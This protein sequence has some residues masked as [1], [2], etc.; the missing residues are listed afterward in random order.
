MTAP[1][2]TP[3]TRGRKPSGNAMS[4][5]ERQKLYR[6]RMKAKLAAASAIP[7]RDDKAEPRIEELNRRLAD[8][9]S[10][11]ARLNREND[12]LAIENDGLKRRLKAKETRESDLCA[13]GS[14]LRPPNRTGRAPAWD[15]G[16]PAESPKCPARDPRNPLVRP[17]TPPWPRA[18][19]CAAVARPD[20]L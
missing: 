19:G 18:H 5:A 7:L 1:A 6:E 16:R 13:G 15:H 20:R 3:K 17:A 2:P 12:R 10:E 11:V 9:L 14:M 4:S 8:A